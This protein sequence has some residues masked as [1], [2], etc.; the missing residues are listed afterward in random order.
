MRSNP[1]AVCSIALLMACFSL[2]SAQQI[3]THSSYS[4]LND[5][6]GIPLT[7]RQNVVAEG[8]P[9]LF[10][11]WHQATIR[12]TNGQEFNGVPT[13]INLFTQEI[14]FLNSKKNEMVPLKGAIQKVWF[15]DPALGEYYLYSTGEI[16]QIVCKVL[17]DGVCILLQNK[18]KRI[19]EEKPFNSAVTTKKFMDEVSYYILLRGELKKLTSSKEEFKRLFSDRETE[20]NQYLNTKKLKLKSEKDVINFV[21]F[22]NG[23]F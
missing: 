15:S 14:H 9:F 7:P 12:L 19:I 23:L 17:V 1:K 16:G 21:R 18:Y 10:E 3:N 22:Y 11:E 4:S 5:L 13:K 2:V 6:S 8:N 20:I